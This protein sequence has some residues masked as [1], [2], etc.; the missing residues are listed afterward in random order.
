M[1]KTTPPLP[2]WYRGMADKIVHLRDQRHRDDIHYSAAM[3]AGYLSGLYMC[4]VID[5]PQFDLLH[6]LL[7]NAAEHALRDS[8][9]AAIRAFAAGPQASRV[10]TLVEN[11]R[12]HLDRLTTETEYLQ[13]H[14]QV[15]L[16]PVFDIATLISIEND[17]IDRLVRAA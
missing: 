5:S 11:I 15:T 1:Q 7:E 6:E 9:P 10:Q 14:Q 13:Q 4:S 12:D 2:L 3:L 8:D 16:A 17:H